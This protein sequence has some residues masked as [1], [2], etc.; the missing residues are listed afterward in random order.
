MPI[1]FLFGFRNRVHDHG[2]TIAATCPR[3]HNSVVLHDMHWRRWFTLFFVPVVPLGKARRVLMCPI[4]RWGRDVPKTAES[5]TTEMGD[6]TRQ[7]QAGGLS[8]DDYGKR[9]DAYWS[10]ATP[11][12]LG[13]GGDD[14]PLSEN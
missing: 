14:V 8:D 4:C 7:W 9:V 5:L 2:A 12:T 3:C 11:A 1:F 10:F 13:A 6:I